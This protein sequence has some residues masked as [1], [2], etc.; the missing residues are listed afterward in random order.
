M[1]RRGTAGPAP[2]LEFG[3]S[4]LDGELVPPRVFEASEFYND[5][6]VRLRLRFMLGGFLEKGPEALIGLTLKNV[7]A[8][9]GAR[10]QT[11]LVRRLL[12]GPA[13]LAR[14]PAD[15]ASGSAGVARPLRLPSP[16]T[17]PASR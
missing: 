10:R 2:S 15:L 16:A 6:Y 4:A 3:A 14:R 7:F 1:P 11:D 17:A 12:Q 5:F 13:A 8:K 9:T